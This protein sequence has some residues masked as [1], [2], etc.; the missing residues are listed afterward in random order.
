MNPTSTLKPAPKKKRT[1]DKAPKNPRQSRPSHVPSPPSQKRSET[2]VKNPTY[3]SY[4]RKAPYQTLLLPLGPLQEFNGKGVKSVSQPRDGPASLVTSWLLLPRTHYS[5]LTHYYSYYSRQ[6]P[7]TPRSDPAMRACQE[8]QQQRRQ[9]LAQIP[10][11][12][13]HPPD[14]GLD[15]EKALDQPATSRRVVLCPCAF[16]APPSS[17]VMAV[18]FLAVTSCEQYHSPIP[19]CSHAHERAT[20]RFALSFA[21]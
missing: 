3:P 6:P 14:P 17:P 7:V 10:P 13:S 4:P 16:S 2:A 15:D 18:F 12:P 21:S 5:L 8:R 11:H 1:N 19:S 20:G 9:C